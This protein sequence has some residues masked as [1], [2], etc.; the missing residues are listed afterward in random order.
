MIVTID[1]PAEGKAR[2]F[3][4]IVALD[5]SAELWSP[6]VSNDLVSAAGSMIASDAGDANSRWRRLVL[7]LQRGEREAKVTEVL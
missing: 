2:F 7:R 6:E 1:R 5:G 3:V 4:Q